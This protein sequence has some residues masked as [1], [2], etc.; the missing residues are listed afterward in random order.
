MKKFFGLLALIVALNFSAV[1]ARLEPVTDNAGVL[2]ST[3]V[4]LLNQM[5]ANVEQAHKIKIGVVFVKSLEGNNIVRASQDLLDRHFNNG[6][7]GSIV[8]LVDMSA[9]KYEI[10][11]NARMGERIT[12]SDGIPFLKNAFKG[13][14]SAGNYFGAVNSFVDGVGEL[15]TYSETNGR[16][17]GNQISAGFDQTPAGFNPMA[18]M[19]AVVLAIFCGVM[20]RSA[21]IGSMSN[22]RHAMEATDYLKRNTV[23]FTEKRDTF[24]FKNVKRRPRSGGGN[25]G[26]GG[27]G[28]GS[29]G[30]GGGSF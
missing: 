30:G 29:H 25:R 16:P 15:M 27:H 20:I 28:G 19:A 17:Y 24:L 12:D 3:E 14:L 11:T 23:N 7:N 2:K 4:E 26:S 1:E 18:A 9:R 8:L 10:S 13:S 22:V 21:L 6:M 5:I